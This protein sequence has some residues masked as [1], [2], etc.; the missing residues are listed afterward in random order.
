MTR[1]C[2]LF[3]FLM[4]RRPPRSTLDRSSAASD[5][6]KRQEYILEV[7]S[8]GGMTK[9]IKAGI[10]KMRIEEASARRQARID[11]G[12]ETIVGVNKHR[13]DKEDPIEILEVDNTAVRLSQ[14]KRL[15]SV[16]QN[17]NDEDVKQT[18]DALSLIHI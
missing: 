8:Y 10:P 4:I 15:Q 1:L 9:A 12:R 7:E 16:K 6:Y 2:G 18:L 13:L 5:V 14:I 17:R 11:S 3:F